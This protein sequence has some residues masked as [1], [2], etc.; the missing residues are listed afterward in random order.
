V[1]TTDLAS[2]QAR[3]LEHGSLADAVAASST[4]PGL[5]PP[6]PIGGERHFDGGSTDPI[7]IAH[8]RERGADIVVAVNIM[9]L[10]GDL[11]GMQMPRLPLPVPALVTN[12]LLGLDTLI[13]E[14][15][16]H[17]CKLADVA[18]EPVVTN[19][20]WYAPVPRSAYRAAGVTATETAV[21]AIR[22]LVGLAASA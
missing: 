3:Y 1:V 14:I 19:V 13:A 9:R 16:N 21:P 20:P 22:D 5:F 18:I 11:L 8:L 7:P 15:S 12:L 17:E 2:R 6:V 4:V 10:G